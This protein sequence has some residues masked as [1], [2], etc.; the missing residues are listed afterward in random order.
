MKCPNCNHD[1]INGVCSH[2]NYITT[3]EFIKR[4]EQIKVKKCPKCGKEM[5]GNFCS[6]CGYMSNGRF[7]K[8]K[9]SQM[10]KRKC[11]K[12]G[13]EMTDDFCS[14]CGYMLN[15]NIIGKKE[16]KITEEEKALGY[17]Y[18]TILRNENYSMVFLLGPVYFCY[19]NYFWLGF[20]FSIL[21]IY[22]HKV[23]LTT[24]TT[25]SFFFPYALIPFLFP[26][27][28][29]LYFILNR[30][31]WITVSN[32]FYLF[33]VRR[34]LQKTKDIEHL[35]YQNRIKL[36]FGIISYIVIIIGAICIR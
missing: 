9:S 14:Y 11:P 1:L 5:T 2:C 7:I 36:I 3:G 21:D 24:I 13:K 17:E 30:F 12:C 15:G 27:Y 29:V 23:A 25:P 32:W 8:M 19:R 22:C 31:F 4:K 16:Q 28:A 20:F 35:K 34:K 6:Y 10:K 33:L 18:N 26:L